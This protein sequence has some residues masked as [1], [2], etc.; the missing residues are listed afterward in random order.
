M[1]F[2][3][4]QTKQVQEVAFSKKTQESFHPNLYFSKFVLEKKQI[5][6]YLRLK[7]D[8]KLSLKGHLKD[9]FA[10]VN[11]EIGIL[12]KLSRFLPRH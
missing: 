12:K 6:K 5:Q 11:R 8:K 2:N 1:A 4:E 10:K 7:L 9:K 3:P